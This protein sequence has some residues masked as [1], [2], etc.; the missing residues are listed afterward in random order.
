MDSLS[1]VKVLKVEGKISNEIVQ[2]ICSIKCV[3]K[4]VR[5]KYIVGRL[6]G[7]NENEELYKGVVC[8]MI[9]VYNKTFL[10]LLKHF[11]KARS[12]QNS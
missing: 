12:T 7:S 6:V 1:F 2:Y 11:L 5:S 3:F 10:A 8:F 4:N 9:V